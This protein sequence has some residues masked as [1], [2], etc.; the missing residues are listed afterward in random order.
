MRVA[1]V[2]LNAKSCDAIGNQVAEKFLFFREHAADVRVFVE[3]AQRL[4][5]VLA[6]HCQTVTAEPRGEFWE[7]LSGADLVC[8]EYSQYYSLL[9]MLPLLAGGRPRI[10][11]DYHSVT[12]PHLWGDH[13]REALA[14]GQEHRGLAWCADLVVAHSQF[15]KDEIDTSSGMP[16]NRSQVLGLPIDARAFLASPAGPSAGSV[17]LEGCR[18]VLFVGRMAPNKRPALLVEAL[19]YL[20]D[21][22][23]PIHVVYA[24]DDDDFYKTEARRCLQLARDHGLADRVHVLGLVPE[25]RL[26][27]LYQ[28]AH[29]L[30]VPSL[31][32]GFC[33]PAVEAMASG[34]PVIA[35]RAAALPETIGCAGLTFKPDDAGDLARQMRRVLEAAPAA[36]DSSHTVFAEQPIAIVSA[37]FGTAFAG[38]AETSLRKIALALMEMGRRVEIYTTCSNLENGHR[39]DLPAGTSMEDGLVVHRF[40]SAAGGKD[41]AGLL[42]ALETRIGALQAV[43]TGPLVNPL[44]VEAAKRWPE[45]V[46]LVPCF[47]DEPASQQASVPELCDRVMGLWYHSAAE[48]AYAETKLGISHP[49]GM[50]I[51]TH[52]AVGAGANAAK[53]HDLL[54]PGPYVVYCGRRSEEKNLSRLFEFARRF[55]AEYPALVRFAFLGEAKGESGLPV[56]AEPWAVDL[57]FLDDDARRD[58]VA[59]ASALVQLST[60]ESLSLVALEAWAVGT[61]VI[62]HRQCAVMAAHVQSSGGGLLVETYEDFEAAIDL[63]VVRPEF[64]RQLGSC[65]REYVRLQYSSAEAFAQRLADA[66]SELRLP[67]TTRM[68]ERG[69]RRA[70]EFDRSTWRQQFAA[71]VE[72]LLDAPGREARRELKIEPRSKHCTGQV[73]GALLIAVR[74]VNTGTVPAM[75]DGPAKT[76]I[77]GEILDQRGTIVLPLRPAASLPGLLLPGRAMPASIALPVPAAPGTYTVRLWTQWL[78]EEGTQQGP[79]ATVQLEVGASDRA[80]ASTANACLLAEVQ[81]ALAEADRARSLPDSYSDVSTGALAGI[82]AA[83]KQKLLGNFKKA[84]VDVLSRQQSDYNGRLIAAV[85]ALAELCATQDHALRQMQEHLAALERR[86]GPIEDVAIEQKERAE[87]SQACQVM[88]EIEL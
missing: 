22:K 73:D 55:D 71:M 87:S 34:V 10:L 6:G 57:G 21:L 54:G 50:V 83:V 60:R 15:T 58:V 62:G 59:G 68:R 35:A 12:P 30:V 9:S 66:L 36:A 65:G 19:R 88:E 17:N 4:H 14:K 37:R 31:W 75:V 85:Q 46:I 47:H 51:G 16:S 33:V 23:P 25:D 5:P 2:S 40:P 72:R 76:V 82:K 20:A 44:A 70:A 41:A 7:Y 48:K 28:S 53:G 74:V 84:Y 45:K 64:R 43:I 1:I 78:T 86:P 69:F 29:A 42:T 61:P 3:S 79:G 67:L 32:E 38:G 63:C 49:G 77:A 11:I 56:P 80:L 26:S 18:I 52:V 8:V 39:K 24:G 81:A 27:A 13:N